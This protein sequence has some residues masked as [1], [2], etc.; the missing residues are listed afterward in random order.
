[1]RK[2]AISEDEPEQEQSDKAEKAYGQPVPKTKFFHQPTIWAAIMETMGRIRRRRARRGGPREVTL[3]RKSLVILCCSLIGLSACLGGAATLVLLRSPSQPLN[4]AVGAPDL[5]VVT[6]PVRLAGVIDDRARFRDIF[7]ALDADHGAQFSVHRRCQQAL[8]QLAGEAPPSATPGVS[9]RPPRGTPPLHIVI[10]P[11][12]FGE[13]V[14]HW[15]LPLQDAATYLRSQGYRV[16][17]VDVGGR[18]SSERNADV[19]ARALPQLL[20]PGERLLIIGYSKGMSDILETMAI[21][22]QAIPPGSAIVSL[23]GIV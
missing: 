9:L 6:V 17:T 18:S 19:I 13:C 22:P 20:K 23:A 7:C 11:G 16:D 12:M 8:Q 3:R 15:V 21:H 14:S 5:P 4:L 2:F 1:M 10:I